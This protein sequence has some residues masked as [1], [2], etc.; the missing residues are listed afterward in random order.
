MDVIYSWHACYVLRDFALFQKPLRAPRIEMR[1]KRFSIRGKAFQVHEI[2]ITP[3][4]CCLLLQLHY[5][6]TAAAHSYHNSFRSDYPFLTTSL[7]VS[8]VL[9]S[10]L[11]R[12]LTIN[13]PNIGKFSWFTL[14]DHSLQSS[15]PRKRK[16][17]GHY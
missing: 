9:G 10:L 14:M 8:L 15:E 5:Y 2:C 13:Y 3:I 1:L 12:R 17:N 4:T 11:P 16:L 7:L 6:N